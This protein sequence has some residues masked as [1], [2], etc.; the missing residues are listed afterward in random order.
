[1]NRRIDGINIQFPIS[2]DILLGSKT[3]ETRT[4]PIPNSY[5][6]KALVLIE[7]PGK[8]GNFKA[9][10]IAIIKFTECFEYK[11]KSDFYKDSKKHLVTKGSKWAW[12]EKAKF[13]WRVVV[14]EKL[15][16]FKDLSKIKKGIVYTKNIS[17]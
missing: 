2:Q 5:L 14:I 1:M 12:K 3:I 11:S 6:N 17:I 4:Y 7:T 16:P 8:L 9:R 13:G 10:A 15:F